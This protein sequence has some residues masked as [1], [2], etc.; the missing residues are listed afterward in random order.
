MAGQKTH[1]AGV[2]FCNWSVELSYRSETSLGPC[3]K[4]FAEALGLGIKSIRSH[5]QDIEFQPP[6]LQ[7]SLLLESKDVD[8]IR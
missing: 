2:W 1:T 6:E 4:S 5:S 7:P 3:M 8:S